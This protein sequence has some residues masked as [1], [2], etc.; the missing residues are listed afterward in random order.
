MF[1][2]SGL[3]RKCSWHIQ[4]K[5]FAPD[6]Y[7]EWHL[8]SRKAAV[9]RRD[10]IDFQGAIQLNRIL[11]SAIVFLGL[12]TSAYASQ[13]RFGFSSGGPSGSLGFTVDQDLL[14]TNLASS[15]LT[16]RA[17]SFDFEY[18]YSLESS[19]GLF[20]GRQGGYGGT[21][22][23]IVSESGFG[24][25]ST[26]IKLWIDGA[27]RIYQ[28]SVSTSGDPCSWYAGH[29][30]G[31][32]GWSGSSCAYGPYVTWPSLNYRTS[33][34]GRVTISG[35]INGAAPIPLPAGFPMLVTGM[36]GLGL[37]RKTRNRS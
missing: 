31:K 30:L 12:A 2:Y 7:V 37:L 21:D 9:S 28:Y 24:E 10:G 16:V 34:P 4:P 25:L 26:F 23:F 14:P 11:V 5:D 1:C 22:K 8:I 27:G 18:F 20:E 3:L 19:D 35:D 32:G 36:A 33:I 17:Y 13:V 6:R 29:T 15:V